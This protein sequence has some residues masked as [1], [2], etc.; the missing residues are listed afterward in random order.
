MM[1]TFITE[2]CSS[3]SNEGN[4]SRFKSALYMVPGSPELMMAVVQHNVVEIM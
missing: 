2:E 1:V 4:W 3:Q